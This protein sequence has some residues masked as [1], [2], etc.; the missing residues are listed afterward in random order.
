MVL[1]VNQEIN[2]LILEKVDGAKVN[3][4]VKE[5]V[6]EILRFERNHFDEALSRY[7]NTYKEIA[8]GNFKKGGNK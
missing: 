4:S 8:N 1:P 2:R 5:F 7:K 6:K 3:L